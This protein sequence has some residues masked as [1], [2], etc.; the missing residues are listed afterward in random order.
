MS[1]SITFS[2]ILNIVNRSFL[3]LSYLLIKTLM[4]TMT[5]PRQGKF[6]AKEFQE[7]YPN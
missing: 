1:G 5:T 2:S 6:G 4:T 7:K 3:A